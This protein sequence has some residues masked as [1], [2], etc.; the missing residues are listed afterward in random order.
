MVQTLADDEQPKL[1]QIVSY[2]VPREV[3]P[4]FASVLIDQM[5]L[6]DPMVELAAF[7]RPEEADHQDYHGKSVLFSTTPLTEDTGLPVH[8]S[9]TFITTSDRRHIRLQLDNDP[10]NQAKFNVWLLQEIVPI[11]YLYLLEHLSIYVGAPNQHFWP[12]NETFPV[13][14]L[15]LPSL[16]EKHLR[17]STRRLFQCA[18]EA[19]RHLTPQEV[20]ILP[21]NS[22]I[23]PVIDFL[24]PRTVT[25]CEE[26]FLSRVTD[27]AE[28]PAVSPPLLRELILASR[29]RLTQAFLPSPAGDDPILSADVLDNLLS[30][31]IGQDPNHLVDLSLLPLEDGTLGTITLS[32]SGPTYYVWSNQ[33]VHPNTTVANLSRLVRLDFD[34]D[35]FLDK[36]LN[37]K[38][39][40][41]A[42]MAALMEEAFPKRVSIDATEEQERF[43]LQFWEQFP[44]LGLDKEDILDFPL[45]PTLTRRQFIS[46]NSCKRGNVP[47]L[48]I[49]VDEP[50][51]QCLSSLG[52]SLVRNSATH[53]PPSLIHILED[54]KTDFPDFKFRDV[55]SALKDLDRPSLLT[56]FGGLDLVGD[57]A[58][59]SVW[60][61]RTLFQD[62]PSNVRRIARALPVWI[63]RNTHGYVPAEELVVLPP[64]LD[65][66]VVAPYIT[67]RHIAMIPPQQSQI[68]RAALDNLD[69]PRIS[70]PH[71]FAA[72]RVNLPPTMLIPAEREG[73]KRLVESILE[74]IPSPEDGLEE[75]RLPNASDFSLRPVREFF[76][77]AEPLFS[78]A[79]H[80][81]DRNFISLEFQDLEP[82]LPLRRLENIDMG[83]FA[84]CAQSIA[85][86]TGEEREV[87]GRIALD[88][89]NDRLP[90]ILALLGPDA[91]QWHLINEVNFIPKSTEPLWRPGTGTEDDLGDV[92][93][94]V[95]QYVQRQLG[96]LVAPRDILRQEC[97]GI[98]W[99]Q[100]ALPV[101]P[102]SE[103]LIR[104]FPAIGRPSVDD[105]VS[106]QWFTN[107]A[108]N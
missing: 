85:G 32:S 29:E 90:L 99:S 82:R 71:L 47:I 81:N 56:R 95:S 2:P 104:A 28:L 14:R 101:V 25:K 39:L 68:L 42:S 19:Q 97:V 20:M 10:G 83:I 18:Y 106:M 70:Y 86:K 58:E 75:L 69:V 73:Y 48:P 34:A 43:I 49:S 3:I 91:H 22:I 98:A 54:N 103:S 8:C 100:R 24:E 21:E 61:R 5:K 63:A 102:L 15:V 45:V 36:G 50:I 23:Q 107:L 55:L 13:D 16:Y 38:E 52:I 17:N 74:R 51:C 46:L 35:M 4:E 44:L 26:P 62:V 31:F 77:R 96:D 92:R 27:D 93:L 6:K 60:A 33:L 53:C 59:F 30:F 1:W 89:L 105:V 12:I 64:G 66:T 108:S 88:I 79:L 40:N 84:Y 72:I 11:V 76:S 9:A 41:S 67:G 80:A 7:I 78:T 87:C 94:N 65:E 37:I 57:R